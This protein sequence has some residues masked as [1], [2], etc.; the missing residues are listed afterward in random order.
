MATPSLPFNIK[1]MDVNP[2]RLARVP[3]ISSVDTYDGFSGNMHDQGLFSRLFGEIGSESRDYTFGRIQLN[4]KIIHPFLFKKIKQIKRLHEDIIFSRK[5]AIFDE[6]SGEFIES[7][8]TGQTGYHFFITHLPKIRPK[9]N[10]SAKR[11]NAIDVVLKNMDKMFLDNYLILPAGLRDLTTDQNGK[12]TEDEVNELYRKMIRLSNSLESAPKNQGPELDNIRADLQRVAN[13]IF[14]YFVSMMEGKKGFLLGRFGSRNIQNGTRNVISSMDTSC[15]DLDAPDAITVDDTFI[16]LYQVLNGCLP[17]LPNLIR[18]NRLYQ[19]SFPQTD[20]LANLVNISTL[21]R[22]QVQVRDYDIDLWTT[23]EGNEKIV[24]RFEKESFRSSP[25][26]V[27]GH[28]L[29]LVYQ[30]DKKYQLLSDIDELPEGWD[31]K[32]VRPITYG[33]FLYL[34]GKDKYNTLKVQVTRYPVI[35]D[36]STYIGDVYCKTTAKSF[37]LKEYENGEYTGQMTRQYPDVKNSIWIS[38]M[39]PHSS[40]IS[41][42]DGDFDG[43]TCTG[44]ILL[45]NEAI[46]ETNRINNTKEAILAVGGGLKFNVGN[47]VTSYTVL[48]FNAKPRVRRSKRE[49]MN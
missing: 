43:D 35:G 15:D 44:T 39:S 16:P 49:M 3:R 6:K 34:V 37:L 26:I 24:K 36:G 48:G 8:I 17:L 38:S 41:Q 40:K 22:E 1:I 45:S 29:G 32:Y 2:Q 10:K 9:K 5:M 7:D 18:S 30:D 28:Y 27:K 33:E 42:L 11:A 19:L 13:E 14:D 4:T 25:I 46:E 20:E 21:K 47:Y 31:K 23:I 12:V